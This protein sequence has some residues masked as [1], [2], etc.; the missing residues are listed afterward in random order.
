MIHR[1]LN[2][3]GIEVRLL[4]NLRRNR[5][6]ERAAAERD[7]WRLLTNFRIG[8][9]LDV[10][11]NEGQF[12]HLMREL[13]PS[14]RIYSFEPMPAVFAKLASRFTAD[15]QVVPVNLGLSD[16]AGTKAMNQSEFSPSSSLLPMGHM[17]KEEWPQSAGHSQVAVKLARLDDWARDNG[18]S[19]AEGLMV[20]LDVQGYE[21]AVIEGGRETIR[22]A[23]LVVAEVSFYEL[24]E[25]QPLF[26]EIHQLLTE[27]GFRYRGSIE[28]H[29]SRKSDQI[30]FADAA[31]E[32]MT[33]GDTP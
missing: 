5:K 9:I 3:M 18:L 32:N 33:L 13:C 8:T 14:D 20:K 10:G 19:G 4:R 12:A 22:R 7:Q 24:Y 26:A 1:L 17:H 23:R 16:Q 25:G 30:L 28:Q 6:A 27:L 29:Y 11:A 31:F 2:A 15:T 21:K